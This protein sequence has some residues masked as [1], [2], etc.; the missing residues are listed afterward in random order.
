MSGLF[1]WRKYMSNTYNNFNYNPWETEEQHRQRLNGGMTPYNPNQTQTP[2]QAPEQQQLTPRQMVEQ[3]WDRSAAEQEAKEK[4]LEPMRNMSTREAIEYAWNKQEEKLKNGFKEGLNKGLKNITTY[5]TNSQQSPT[6]QKFV[7]TATNAFKWLPEYKT[8]EDAKQE[9]DR[10]NKNGYDNYAHRLGMCRVGQL[11]NSTW[12]YSPA[13]GAGL[14]ILKEGKDLIDKSY[15]GNV[16]FKEALLDSLKDMKNNFEGL[17]Y[18]INNP[19]GDCR[20]WLTDLDY[21][22]N[23]WRR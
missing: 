2:Y 20:K 8:L 18:G 12:P 7:N 13:I 14:G 10:V 6:F 17:N 19:N 23:E 4:E 22:K 21:E 5:S 9:M 16:P 15:Y 1:L 3:A 11:T